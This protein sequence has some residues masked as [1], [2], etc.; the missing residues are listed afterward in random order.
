MSGTPRA[1][2]LGAQLRRVRKEAGLSLRDLAQ[3]MGTTF[4]TIGKW[5]TGERSPRLEDV[6]RCLDA[7]EVD[8][9]RREELL[10]LAQSTDGP[11]WIAVGMPAPPQQLVALM[12][13]ERRAR[14]I[15][16]VTPLIVPG[17]LQTADY[18]RSMMTAS[19]MKR[20]E[21]ETRVA[22]RVGRRDVLHRNSL[23]FTA[24]IGEAALRAVIGGKS[25][26]IDQLRFLLK[27]GQQ[28]NITLRL[29]SQE[30]DW[31][32]LLEGQFA[33]ITFESDDPIAT[34][35]NQIS[36]LFFHRPKDV[37]SF[38]ERIDQLLTTSMELPDTLGWIANRVTYLESL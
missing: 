20:T 26:M 6:V 10:D 16:E 23:H 28:P 38:Q 25:V 31:N 13:F 2:A 30:S 36:S 34:S 14:T 35:E 24:I 29:V 37:A 18:A 15:T 17:L 4:S 3:K 7:L 5:E 32:P 9:A 22:M 21:V 33:V 12:D 8:G 19:G 11:H 1:R 27:W